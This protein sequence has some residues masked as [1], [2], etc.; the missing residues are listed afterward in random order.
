MK[1]VKDLLL[2][3]VLALAVPFLV[4]EGAFRLLPVT[5]P[6][7]LL[8]VAAENPVAR[9]QPN[10][11]YRYSAGW[12][13]AIQSRKRSNNFGYNNISDYHPEKTA[14]LLMVIGDSFVEAH[15]VDAGKSA[16]EILKL[17]LAGKGRV[18]SVGLSGPFGPCA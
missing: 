6:P 8:P 11:E 12:N 14:P 2:Y 9:F 17:R 1:L 7:H 10:V 4:L 3:C 18:Y 16:A 13:F 5:D 15:A